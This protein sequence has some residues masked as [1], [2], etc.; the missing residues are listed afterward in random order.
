MK[1][2]KELVAPG[3][4]WSDS[5]PRLFQ[6]DK[7]SPVFYLGIKEA[8]LQGHLGHPL[9]VQPRLMPTLGQAWLKYR[10]R[11]SLFFAVFH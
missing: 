6:I 2:W 10:P 8:V 9:Q 1:L 7:Y 4:I 3:S 5:Q 11:L